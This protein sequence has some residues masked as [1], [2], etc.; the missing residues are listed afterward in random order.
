ME[1]FEKELNFIRDE[2]TRNWTKEV[3]DKVSPKFFEEAASTTGKYHPSY[4]LGEGG[5][6]RHT[7]AA[8]KIAECLRDNKSVHNMSNATVDLCIA[9]LILHD[10]CKCGKNWESKY[11]KHN[12]PILAA[13]LV[14][15]VLG[16]DCEYGSKK[17]EYIS[18]VCDMIKSHM[19]QWTTCKWDK[20]V[21]PEPRSEE[22]K[23]VHL[24]DYLASRKFIEINFEE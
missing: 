14:E 4:A 1:N 3:L 5:L 19:G 15:E 23:F 16:N 24:C 18:R 2:E 22:D 12:H 8:V 10:C 21:L 7:V 20:T 9:A 11:T 6:Y 17:S 13:E